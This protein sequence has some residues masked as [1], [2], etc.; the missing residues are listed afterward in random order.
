VQA[1]LGI[2]GFGMFKGKIGINT[3]VDFD[4]ALLVG[5]NPL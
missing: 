1:I 5:E 2:V 4:E 3:C